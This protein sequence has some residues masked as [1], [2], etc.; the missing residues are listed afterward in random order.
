MRRLL[1]GFSFVIFCLCLSMG[2]AAQPSW[3]KKAVKSV[4]T[5]KTFDQNGTLLGSATGFFVG[6]DGEALSSFA[7]FKGASRAVVIDASGKEYSV[8]CILGANDTYDVA[9][10]RVSASKTQPL[11]VATGQVGVGTAV[12]LLPYREAKIV[13]HGSIDKAETFSGSYGYY[14]VALTMPDGCVGAPLLDDGG[15]VV[16][17]MQQPYHTGDAV[18][19]AVSAS[20]ADSLRI[21]GLSIN[22]PVLKSTGIKKALPDDVD[23]AQLT[24]YL[25]GAQLDSAA[26]MALVDDFIA[27]FPKS[28]EGFLY[29]AQ[30][31][32]S[33]GHFDEADRDIEAA[34]KVDDKPDEVHYSYSRL[35]YQ[36]HLSAQPAPYGPWT[37][38]KALEEAQTAYSINAMPSYRH[39]QAFILFAM[40]RYDEAGT[41]YEELFNTPLRSPDLFYEAA[42]CKQM[43]NDTVAQM[44]L[45]DSCLALFS[46]PY[47]K[48]AAPYLLAVSQAKM[49]VGKNRE[50]VNLLNDYEQL[51]AASVNDQFYYLR[52][53]AE[54]A[55]R[56]FQQALNDISK[57]IE[58][59]PASDL[60]Y[61]EKASLQVRVGL[62]D[63]AME[64]AKACISIAPDHS[65]GYLFLGLSQ[66]L[67]GMKAEGLKNLQKAKEMGDPQAGQLIENYSK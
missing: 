44:A 34:L 60:Y 24:L 54:V 32:A 45:L 58:M 38:E 29:R 16:G 5:L 3:A 30:A 37:L 12:W 25:A 48:E 51:M 43:S 21:T 6:T 17:M 63:D 64:T 61:A 19:Y 20:F 2:A 11:P 15:N 28:Q 39:Q 66:C 49:A 62:Y 27:K 42:R 47:L 26:Y 57:A 8:D 7:P 55:G 4:F 23:Q 41:V 46:K 9:R 65:D 1:L 14:T 40:K 35:I 67:K 36:T 18:S 59:N 50:A 13:P 52:Y 22:D 53:Q 33:G 56:L 31:M 10:F